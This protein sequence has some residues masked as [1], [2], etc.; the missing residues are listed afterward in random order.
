MDKAVRRRLEKANQWVPTRAG[1]RAALFFGI[2]PAR[3]VEVGGV[4]PYQVDVVIRVYWWTWLSL[5]IG[6]YLIS[7]R[8]RRILKRCLAPGVVV[9]RLV[10]TALKKRTGQTR[11][12]W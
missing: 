8:A 2:C 12:I 1:V 7:R 6:H 3:D 9:D 10:V 11:A 5:G 4:K